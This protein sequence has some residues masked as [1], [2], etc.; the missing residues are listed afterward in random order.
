MVLEYLI[1]FLLILLLTSDVNGM[2]LVLNV[3]MADIYLVLLDI[4]INFI[5]M[6]H[7]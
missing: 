7:E 4:Y 6:H 2:A 1:V 3:L 5:F